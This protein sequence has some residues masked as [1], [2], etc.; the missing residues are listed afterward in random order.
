LHDE[1]WDELR[2]WFI[3]YRQDDAVAVRPLFEALQRRIERALQKKGCRRE[4]TDDLCQTILLKIHASR[5]HYQPALPLRGWIV[6]IVERSLIDFWR[7][8]NRYVTESIEAN[9]LVDEGND[10]FGMHPD[11]LL[12][13]KDIIRRLET[14]KPLDRQIVDMF[15]LSGCSIEEIG[16]TLKMTPGAVKLRLHRSRKFL[17][18]VEALLAII[19]VGLNF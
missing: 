12:N 14:L 13:I 9:D 15:A 8:T 3:A 5:E 1:S 2:D 18:T 17:Q 7:K 19:C 11:N 6:T 4:D 16:R 10:W